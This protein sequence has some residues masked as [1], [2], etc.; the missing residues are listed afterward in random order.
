MTIDGKTT[1]IRYYG[2]DTP[3][4][5]DRCYREATDRNK[6]LVADKVLLLPDA[7]DQDKFNRILR[8]VFLSDGTSVDATL[9]AGG[10]RPRLA[11]G[12]PLQAGD[13][14]PRGPGAGTARGCLWK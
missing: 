9:V 8:Y 10:L 14:R 1:R 11:P 12:R 4:R 2:V 7:R 13:H 5:G 3:E 6:K